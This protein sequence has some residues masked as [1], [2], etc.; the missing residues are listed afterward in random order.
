MDT[1]RLE[2]MEQM[3]INQESAYERLYRWMQSIIKNFK[4][5]N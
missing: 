3:A 2:I 1:F 4:I 5:L